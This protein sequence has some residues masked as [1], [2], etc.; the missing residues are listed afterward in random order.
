[1][2]D[3]PRTRAGRLQEDMRRFV[4]ADDLVRDRAVLDGQL[5]HHAP[6]PLDALPDCLGDVLRLAEAEAHH[7]LA[8][9]HHGEGGEG[10]AAPA[11]D[12]LGRP[13][14]LDQ[15][16]HVIVA[17]GVVSPSSIPI[18]H[19]VPLERDPGLPGA[20][21]DGFHYAVVLVAVAVEV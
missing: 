16:F 14:E 3:Y 21:G 2:G 5:D 8:V 13:V 7:A 10:E 6:G 15:L 9:A 20:V 4:L 12:D 11:L 18:V 19:A 1:A 17:T